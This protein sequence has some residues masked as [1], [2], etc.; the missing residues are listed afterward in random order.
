AHIAGYLSQIEALC[1][2]LRDSYLSQ[3]DLFKRLTELL[4]R[5]AHIYHDDKPHPEYCG[6][7]WQTGVFVHPQLS[8]VVEFD[9]T[10]KERMDFYSSL[11]DSIVEG[12]ATGNNS[13]LPGFTPDLPEQVRFGV[14]SA[15]K[16]H[17]HE[18]L[19]PCAQLYCVHMLGRVA[20][21]NEL[22]GVDWLPTKIS[23][24]LGRAVEFARRR[25]FAGYVTSDNRSMFVA[26]AKNRGF[27]DDNLVEEF[28]GD[29]FL[30]HGRW[31]TLI[32][33]MNTQEIDNLGRYLNTTFCRWLAGAR[34]M[35]SE[36]K[37][38]AI[39]AS[40]VGDIQFVEKDRIRYRAHELVDSCRTILEAQDRKIMDAWLA[41]K[42]GDGSLKDTLRS[43]GISKSSYYRRLQAIQKTLEGNDAIREEVSNLFDWR[44]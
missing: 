6:I 31:N 37:W 1:R 34:R 35:P 17:M 32:K 16:E 39:T 10:T 20:S 30:S 29:L 2:K 43:L 9:D 44:G 11:H 12:Y 14:T 18:A 15:L 24:A 7:L 27:H 38:D 3:T 25:T 42:S 33:I 40:E 28:L 8:I 19:S 36:V 22:M 23:P 41:T 26:I 21:L 4:K 13:K 5:N